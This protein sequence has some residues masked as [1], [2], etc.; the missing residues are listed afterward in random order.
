[1]KQ[2]IFLTGGAGFIGACI[3]DKLVNMGYETAS[4]D[5]LVNFIDNEAYYKQ[6]LSI[7]KKYYRQPS[8]IYQG[9]IR[10]K[11]TLAKSIKDFKPTILVHLAGLSMARP[12]PQFANQMI[13]INMNG[14]FNVLE[15]FEKS[16]VE[17]LVYTS[18]S[19]AYGHFKQTPQSENFILE[20]V[21]TYGACKAAGEY[22]VKL[23]KKDWLIIRPTSVYGFTDCA[24]RVSQLLLDAAYLKKQAWV[25][26]GETLDFSYVDDVAEGFILSMF[27]K[28]A[29]HQTLNLSKGEARGATEFAEV[30]KK[31]FPTFT[32]EVREPQSQQVYRGPQDIEKAKTLIGFQP[33]YSIE[34]G[35]E[36]IVQLTEEYKFYSYN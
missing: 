18:S 21:N 25:V 30:I 12:L 24:N 14:T 34:K 2:K 27:N 16:E 32:Y 7:R 31:Y 23:S 5:Q 22:F 8:K 36:K 3:I 19:M 28:N 29:N 17:K 6:C 1:M 33:Q 26:K 11:E 13:P 15:I 10:D 9:D 4:F 35:I 20:P